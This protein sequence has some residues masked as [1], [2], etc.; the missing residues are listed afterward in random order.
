MSLPS[1]IGRVTSAGS[2]GRGRAYMVSRRKRAKRRPALAML[3]LLLAGGAVAWV[4]MNKTPAGGPVDAATITID[5]H[6]DDQPEQASQTR[7]FPY[8]FGSKKAPDVTPANVELKMGEGLAQKPETSE[9]A[10]SEARNPETRN[11]ETQTPETQTPA[12]E[13]ARQ[14]DPEPVVPAPPPSP[15][16]GVIEAAERELSKNN[17]IGARA[18]LNEA[19]ASRATPPSLLPQIRAMLTDINDDLIFSARLFPGET[20][21]EAYEVQPGDSLSK[22]AMHQGLATDWRLIQ[23]VNK[24][25]NPTR[26]RVGQTLKLVRGPFHAVVHKS[27]YRLDLYA[28]APESPRDWTYVRSF[29]VGLGEGDSTPTGDFVVRQDSKLVNPHWVNPRTGERFSAEDPK[30][31]IGERWLGLE[32]VGEYAALSGYGIH[33]TID[34]GSIGDQRSMGCVRLNET[35]IELV[36]ELLTE[37]VSRVKIMD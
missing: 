6:T 17:P 26:I 5:E 25:S 32:G 34:P 28:G 24:I 7:P 21:T 19:M 23:R 14:P 29:D 20:L 9:A 36:Y 16:T 2:A 8:E 27:D 33:G 10:T 11:P 35:D 22:I 18:I 37:G 3:V 13:A 1:Q 31:P 30:N 4:W 15:S 12:T